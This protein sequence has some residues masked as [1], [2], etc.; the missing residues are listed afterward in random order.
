MSNDTEETINL[1]KHA[2]KQD[3]TSPLSE[4]QQQ[5]LEDWKASQNTSVGVL[6]TEGFLG[7]V[8]SIVINGLTRN[9]LLPEPEE[10]GVKGF[11]DI[12]RMF[13]PYPTSIT[14]KTITVSEL[15][16]LPLEYQ[17][18]FGFVQTM[19][20]FSGVQSANVPDHGRTITLIPWWVY[21]FLSPNERLIS[22][23]F[24]TV[25]TVGVDHLDLT[26]GINF[27]E[28]IAYGFLN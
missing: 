18:G 8:L 4:E 19:T 17:T 13:S 23:Q 6:S 21:E 7:S 12:W 11:R 15:R 9:A 2:D 25:F 24:G 10:L 26:K 3:F 14:E 1:K 5:Q 28:H 22:W 20:N 27:N 16:K